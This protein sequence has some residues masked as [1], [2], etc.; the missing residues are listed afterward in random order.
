MAFSN[1]SLLGNAPRENNPAVTMRVMTYNIHHGR[2]VDGVVDL[3]RIARVILAEQPDVVA[4]QEV[5]RGVRRTDRRDLPRELSE[6]TGMHVFFERNIVHEG[7]DYGNAV[8]TRFPVVKEVNTHLRMIREG[9]QRGVVQ[10]VLDAEGT[11]LLFMNTH[12]D[13]R[14]DDAERLLNVEQFREIAATYGDLPVVITGDF[15]TL[16]GTR[17]HL[18]M[19]EQFTDAWEVA[20]EGPGYTFPSRKPNRRIDYLFTSGEIAAKRAW[21]PETQASDHLPLVV[22]LEIPGRPE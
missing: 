22:D 10:M 12:I 17:T 4:L 3:D 5:D 8:L 19:K 6:L 14:P 11:H 13:Y 7:G 20:G 9:E 15:N 16:P 2:G 18:K 21:I 1:C